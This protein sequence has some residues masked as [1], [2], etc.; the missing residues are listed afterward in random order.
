MTEF[1]K[2]TTLTETLT[3][4]V[5]ALKACCTGGDHYGCS[6]SVVGDVDSHLPVCDAEH[7]HLLSSQIR[8]AVADGL[9]R[10][11]KIVLKARETDPNRQIYNE[12]MCAKI[13]AL[14]LAFCRPLQVLA[15]AYFDALTEND[16][17]LHED[18]KENN[19]LDGLLDSDFDPNVLLEES[20]S[21]QAADSIHNHYILQR[22]KAEAWQ[23][24]VAQGLTDAVAFES[25]NRALILAEEKV[26]R[27][28]ALEEKRADK[29]RVLNIMEARAELKW[30]T[31][32]QRR[33]TELSL[34]KMAAD[35]ISDVDAVPLFLAN[36]ILDEALRATIADHTRQ[37]IK[38]L[39]S[40]PEDMNIR[41]LRNNNENLICDYGHPCL[42]AFHPETG[43]R[44]VCQAVVCA[45]EVLWYRMGYTIRYTKVPNRFLDV[46]RGEARARSLRLPCGRSLSEHTYE[47]M[48]F[49][50]YSERLFELVEPDAV[51]RADEWM[52]WYTMI[53]RMESTLTSMLPRSYR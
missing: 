14:F 7:M 23:S 6:E 39:L 12:A 31:E 47:P 35:A 21:L 45:A 40:T 44:C 10:L 5:L 17:S 42:S 43:E 33:G 4:Y 19:L 2:L 34:L 22:A 8:E 3:E 26:S 27:V 51:E 50:D 28:A 38:A 53:Q 13:E 37:L 11:R 1:K 30:Q 15:P 46:A 52:E 32:L 49:E 9:P 29:L 25:Q 48:G 18:G 36:S 20:A 41:R 16:A 24:R